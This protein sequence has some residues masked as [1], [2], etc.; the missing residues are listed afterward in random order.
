MNT[1]EARYG[2]GVTL[3]LFILIFAAAAVLINVIFPGLFFGQVKSSA[4]GLIGE[5]WNRPLWKQSL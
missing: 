4:L 5:I 3:L 2:G 1:S